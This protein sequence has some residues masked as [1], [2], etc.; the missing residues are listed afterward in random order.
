M[1][2]S[3]SDAR[4]SE[5]E[6]RQ[7]LI[8]SHAV[9]VIVAVGPNMFYTV[10]LP[11]TLCFFDE[12]K[13]N[14]PRADIVFF[15]DAR[16]ICWHVD[17]AH[18]EWG[19]AQIGFLAN[20]VRLYRSEEPDFTLGGEEAKAKSLVVEIK[21]AASNNAIPA[22]QTLSLFSI[23]TMRSP[24]LERSSSPAV[25]GSASGTRILQAVASALYRE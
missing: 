4:A 20:I 25:R 21:S 3:A 22:K 23:A 11:C 17:R 7:K 5:Q 19:P 12:G 24:S 6:L 1:A 15:I 2:N 8:E 13:V 16:L 18:R 14:T 10:T 9:E